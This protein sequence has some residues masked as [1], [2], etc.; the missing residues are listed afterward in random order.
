[1]FQSD[2]EALRAQPVDEGE[3]PVSSV[4]VLTK[5][6]PQN[7]S[8]HFLKNVGI[9]LVASKKSSSSVERELREK[10][11]ASEAN[12]AAQQAKLEDLKKK[13]EEAADQLART[14]KEMEEYKKAV[15]ENNEL[16]RRLFQFGARG[17]SSTMIVVGSCCSLG[18]SFWPSGSC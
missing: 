8:Q 5:V 15:D 13:S 10:L 18:C 14:Q 16:M 4:Q 9:K 12:S 6:L 1:M 7:S 2:M 17:S 11:A 3:A